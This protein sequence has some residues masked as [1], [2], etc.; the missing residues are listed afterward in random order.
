MKKFNTK[1]TQ[2]QIDQIVTNI[3][4]L[5][6]NG[7]SLNVSPTSQS[8]SSSSFFVQQPPILQAK[9]PETPRANSSVSSYRKNLLKLII[10]YC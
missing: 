2:Q 9:P 5:S 6:S 4:K 10:F 3:N 7:S 8:S 1:I